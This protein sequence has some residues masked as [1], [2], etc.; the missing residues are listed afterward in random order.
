MIRSCQYEFHT[1]A[2]KS[3]ILDDAVFKSADLTI[4]AIP[5]IYTKWYIYTKYFLFMATK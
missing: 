3:P 1:K 2:P 5:L 4:L